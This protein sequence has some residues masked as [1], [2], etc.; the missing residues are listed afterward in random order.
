[1]K[2][3]LGVFALFVV[4][5]SHALFSQSRNEKEIQYNLDSLFNAFEQFHSISERKFSLLDLPEKCGTWLI[6]YLQ[7]HRNELSLQQQRALDERL[8]PKFFQKD[9][10]IGN[11][12]L[13]FNVTGDSAAALLDSNGNRIAETARAY[14]ESVA[15]YLNHSYAFE[16]DSLGYHSL[17]SLP[18]RVEIRALNGL[19]G[20]AT[21]FSL[22]M[23]NDYKDYTTRGLAAAKVTAAHELHHVIQYTYGSN[24]PRFFME[25]T[26]TWM[27]DVVYNE[28]NDYYNYLRDPAGHF[29]NPKTSFFEEN[30]I[31]KYSRAIWGKFLEDKFL[32]DSSNKNI[33][34]EI[35]RTSW[36]NIGA[37]IP[38]VQAIDGAAKQFGGFDNLYAEFSYWHFFIGSKADTVRYFTEGKQYYWFEKIGPY[39][40]IRNNVRFDEP[41]VANRTVLEIENTQNNFSARYMPITFGEDTVFTMISRHSVNDTSTVFRYTMQAGEGDTLFY[42]LPNHYSARLEY[43]KNNQWVDADS[44]WTSREL[45]TRFQSEEKLLVYPNPFVYDGTQTL[46]IQLPPKRKGM[47]A[48]LILSS[49][50][51]AVF[52][53]SRMQETEDFNHSIGYRNAVI[54]WNGTSD[55]G[56]IPSSGIY[57]YVLTV[58]D[59]HWTGKFAFIRK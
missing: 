58:N 53:R 4:V 57:F 10:T 12:H 30:G 28:V 35:M 25:L 15:V 29:A 9:T 19:Y 6:Q 1:M 47:I 39:Y 52:E 33:G 45:I 27:E 43:F 31:I 59:K 21:P 22:T 11:V 8:F 23:D 50:L 2:K 5:F 26:S 37:N 54:E 44:N 55:D 18:L 13:Y 32:H 20:Y 46:K 56:S 49:D 34:R 36:N 42:S 3:T 41:I 38:I 16:V 7:T 40:Y 24:P 14:V 17:I 51:T 48:L